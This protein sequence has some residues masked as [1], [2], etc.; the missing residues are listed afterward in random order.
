MFDKNLQET[1][2]TVFEDLDD[3]MEKVLCFSQAKKGYMIACELSTVKA[4]LKD[5]D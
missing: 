4:N 3:Y 5:C 2:V 1:Q